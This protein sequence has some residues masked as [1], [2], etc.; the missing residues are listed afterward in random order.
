MLLPMV[1]MPNAEH[2]PLVGL[3]SP[4]MSLMVVVLPAP[5]G[6]RKPKMD[7][8]GTLRSSD[9]RTGLP[10]YDLVSFSVLITRS[11]VSVM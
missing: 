11:F 8:F 1:S 2:V 9:L 7:C 4:R 10:L 5:F 6:P 3:I